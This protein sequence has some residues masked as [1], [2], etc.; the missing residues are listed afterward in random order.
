MFLNVIGIAN[1]MLCTILE[2]DKENVGIMPQV[3][4]PRNPK[5]SRGFKWDETDVNILK[6]FF[7]KIPKAPGHYCR[8][9]S[10]KIYLTSVVKTMAKLYD[11]YKARCRALNRDSF[12]IKKFVTYFNDNNYS[13][14]KRKKDNCNTCIGYEEG[15][16]SQHDFDEHQA[17]KTDGFNRKEEDKES[18]DG[19]TIFVITADT[20]SLLTAPHND[21]NIMFFHSKLNLHNFTF[22][23]LKT[24]EV[25]NFLWNETNG[26][27]ESNN[28]TSCYI[29]YLEELIEAHRNAKKIILWSDGCTYQNRCSTLASALLQLCVNYKVELQQKYL[30]VGHTHMECDSV[31]SNIEKALKNTKIN[32]PSDYIQVIENARKSKPGKYGVR[33]LDFTFFRDF[34]SISD[35]K[36]LK[37]TKETGYPFVTNIRQL[38][39]KPDGTI[40][41]NLT[42][43]DNEWK[44]LPHKIKLRSLTPHLYKE[45]LKISAV[46]YGHLQ[47]IKR[48]IP[49]D[50]HSYYDNLLHV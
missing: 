1:Q 35:I 5:P 15:N 12:G 16:V 39:Y 29:A 37:P 30:E 8:K 41:S 40:Y 17:L 7:D 14:F 43:D 27:I 48:T 23:D 3:R 21:A 4:K 22:Y 32:L 2:G 11:I 19:K 18:A 42:Y 24:R 47:D 6:D 34:K 33:Y 31:H 28:S 26:E 49:S 10:S 36:S 50:A 9:D 44:P 20:E 13:L 38:W 46:K 25:M 45:H